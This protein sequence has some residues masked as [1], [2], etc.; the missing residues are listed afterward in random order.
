[1]DMFLS[2]VAAGKPVRVPGTA[3]FMTSDTNGAPLVLLHHLKHNKVLHQQVVLLSI[4]PAGVPDIPETERVSV[5][6]LGEG[7]WRVLARYGFMETPDVPAVMA[8]CAAAGIDTKPLQTT[9]YLGR[10]SLILDRKAKTRL[11]NWRKVLFIFMSK[12]SRPATQFFQIPPNRVV[13][14]GA[15]IRF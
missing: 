14:L 3:I 9:Y 5:T 12:N 13:E 15:Q 6:Q 8:R 7:F 11:A 1:M 2:N 10:E 4:L